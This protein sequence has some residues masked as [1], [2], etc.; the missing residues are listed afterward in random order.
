MSEVIVLE[1]GDV[2]RARDEASA[3]GVVHYTRRNLFYTL[4]RAGVVAD[5]GGSPGAAMETFAAALERYEI[6]HGELSGLVRPESVR[7][8][9][10]GVELPPDIFDYAVRRVLVFQSLDTCLLFA[11][12]G[13]HRKIEVGLVSTPRFPGHVWDRL[14][15]QLE[16]GYRTTFYAV[17]DC[18]VE[19]IE[20]LAALRKDLRGRKGATVKD[21]GLTFGWAFRLRLPVRSLDD[22][23]VLPPR[24][25]EVTSEWAAMAEQGNYAEF[26]ELPAVSSMAWVYRRI[27][28]AAEDIGF[29]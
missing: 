25:R 27:A 6:K 24:R 23:P 14:D 1:P 9:L 8:S 7:D 10:E 19:G 18:S 11:L 2:V 29:G 22:K 17:H 16:E 21:V 28:K 4:V 13:F 20:W 3:G 26:E 12:N 5:P 15:G